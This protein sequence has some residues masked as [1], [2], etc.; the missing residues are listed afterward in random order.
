MSGYLFNPQRIH[1]RS[2]DR[3]STHA[4]AEVF[5]PGAGWITFDPTN[6]SMGGANLIPVAVTRRMAQS[7]PVMG[8]YKGRSDALM[9]MEVE[10]EVKAINDTL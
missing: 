3:G 2:G 5:L 7:V 6:Q 10:V 9:S 8:S 4:W 1:I